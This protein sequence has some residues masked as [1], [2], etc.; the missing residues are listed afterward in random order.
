[1]NKR[2]V[3]A[4]A[5]LFL[6]P[7][8]GFVAPTNVYQ[9]NAADAESVVKAV[10]QMMLA[11]D[12]SAMLDLTSGT[13]KQKTQ[14]IVDSLRE[15]PSLINDLK[16]EIKKILEFEVLRTEYFTNQNTIYS[17]VATKW[18]L[19][20]DVTPDP[21]T[22]LIL[23]EAGGEQPRQFSVVQVDYLLQ[24]FDGKWKIISQRSR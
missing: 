15:N 23:P 9:Y 12:F 18:T 11:A 14:E 1:M 8:A 4:F 17:I 5:L 21:G 19:K 10:H 24:S 6:L 2:F 7:A 13:E 20:V 3:L 22:T 16:K